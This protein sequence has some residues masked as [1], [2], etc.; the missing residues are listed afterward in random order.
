MKTPGAFAGYRGTPTNPS[1]LLFKHH[2]LHIELVLDRN[3]PIGSTDS[4]LPDGSEVPEGIIDTLVTSLI[5]LH[6]LKSL[7]KLRNSRTGSIYIVK[8]KMHGPVEA[9]FANRLFDAVEDV[10]GL[11]R[12][13]VKLGLMDEE[14][15]TSANLAACIEAVKNRIVFIN[16]GF[17]DRTGDEIHTSM[18]AGAVTRKAAMKSS[19]WMK[20]AM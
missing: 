2:G 7:G 8:P 18:H 3:H 11:P 12:Y 9:G 14:R 13:T 1:N 5:G 15:R 17:L 6:D 4:R 20:T 19:A 10:L 16:T